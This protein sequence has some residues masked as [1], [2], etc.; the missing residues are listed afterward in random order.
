M[1]ALQV[2]EA[3]TDRRR[4]AIALVQLANSVYRDGNFEVAEA[5]WTRALAEYQALGESRYQQ[6]VKLS[7]GYAA[8]R[9]GKADESRRLATEARDYFRRIGETELVASSDELMTRLGPP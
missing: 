8:F 9:L 4:V 6:E 5:F 2:A 1:E 3:A 7:L